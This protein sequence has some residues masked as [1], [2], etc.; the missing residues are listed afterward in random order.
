M[1]R[2]ETSVAPS[3]L[4][5]ATE[6]APL[7]GE[8]R[9]RPEDFRVEEVAAYE[10]VGA[11]DHLFVWF[12]KVDLGTPEAVR[13]LARALGADPKQAGY[14]GLKDRRAVTRQWASF[15]FGDPDR[16]E[17]ARIDGVRV[18]RTARHGHKLRTGHL[19]GNRFEILVRGAP[20]ERLEDVRGQLAALSR[21]GVPSYFGPQ[22]FGRDGANLGD[23]VRWLLE[24]GRA[25]KQRF[26]RKLLVSALQSALF[27][28][29]LAERVREGRLDSLVEGDLMQ[30]VD[31]GGLFVSEDLEVD[32]ARA[33]RFEIS[34]TGPMFGAK[35]R[36]PEREARRREEAALARWGM[37]EG[38]L[39]SFRKAGA[40]ARRPYRVP[41]EAPVAEADPDGIR[42]SFGL[43]S[44][45][46][47]TVVLRE[48]LRRDVR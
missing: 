39:R 20:P 29:L 30:K 19:R 26:R 27:N 3:D 13:R 41:L 15:L 17:G 24:G 33:A 18:L 10:P 16:L 46:Y 38:T 44:G 22:R 36:W 31:T 11:G 23:A 47:A 34:A 40:G 9:A 42:L 7:P 25:P 5:F 35:M 4:P 32:R 43:P 6:A 8:I 14:A 45:A 2:P 28:E 12:E 37:D 1:T 21:R 48:L